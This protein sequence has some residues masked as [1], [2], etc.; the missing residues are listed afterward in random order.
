[1]SRSILIGIAI[2]AFYAMVFG[3]SPVDRIL[4]MASC[5]VGACFGHAVYAAGLWPRL[6]SWLRGDDIHLY[7]VPPNWDGPVVTLERPWMFTGE[8]GLLVDISGV[9]YRV[10]GWE[11]RDIALER[12]ALSHEMRG[13]ANIIGLPG[14]V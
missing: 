14:L 6:R 4:L 7:P 5:I 10:V 2:G 8:P 12:V 1:M 13:L 9:T 3:D 11:D